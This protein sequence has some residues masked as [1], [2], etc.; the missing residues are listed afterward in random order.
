MNLCSRKM[1]EEGLAWPTR[2]ASKTES[3]SKLHWP[4]AVKKVAGQSHEEDAQGALEIDF[5]ARRRSVG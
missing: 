2:S 4:C 3:E 1:F 5:R